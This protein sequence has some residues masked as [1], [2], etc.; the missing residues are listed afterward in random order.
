MGSSAQGLGFAEPRD[1]ARVSI[2]QDVGGIELFYASYRRH[3][4]DAHFH[5]DFSL[6]VS[7]RGGLAFDHRG[8]KHVAPTGV[9]S[10]INPSDLH[11]SY[12]ANDEGW[13]IV[14]LLIPAAIFRNVISEISERDLVPAFRQRVID[15]A[16][17]ARRIVHLHRTL[18][19][20]SDPLERQS[21]VLS[22]CAHLVQRH[23]TGASEL[24][25]ATPE[26]AAVRRARDFLHDCFRRSV[27]LPELASVAGLSRFHFL[28]VFRKEVGLTPHAY[29]NY[30]RVLEAKRQLIAGRSIADAALGSGFADQS[31][32][33]RRF[34]E[35]MGFTPGLVQHG[36]TT[37]QE[38]GRGTR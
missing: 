20:S 37:H 23:T 30:L 11:N 35:V 7:L 15:D 5:D 6:G 27:S 17:M 38:R 26:R 14:C 4:F 8:S 29:L 24:R 28:R 36:R 10:A 19:L 18:E 13:T 9:I 34:K 12:P 2:A 3:R 32:L 25:S 16:L 33:A 21:Q 22:T 1:V 31:H